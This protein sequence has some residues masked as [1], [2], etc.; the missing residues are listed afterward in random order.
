MLERIL[1]HTHTKALSR[2]PF[3]GF[4]SFFFWEFPGGLPV[5]IQCLQCCGLGSILGQGTEILQAIWCSQKKFFF[6]FLKLYLNYKIFKSTGSL[7]ELD[8]VHLNN[9]QTDSTSNYFFTVFALMCIYP[10]I[11][12]CCYSYYNS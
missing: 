1:H 8:N 5:R 7:Q 9:D 2:V 3:V 10:S 6:N 11:H 4:K 12:F